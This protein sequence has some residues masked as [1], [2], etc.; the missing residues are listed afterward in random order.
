MMIRI[1]KIYVF[2]EN[3]DKLQKSAV[4]YDHETINVL[5]DMMS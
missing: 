5:T 2:N 4:F 1:Q 3:F